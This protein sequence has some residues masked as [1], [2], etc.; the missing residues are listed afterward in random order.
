[1]QYSTTT[2]SLTEHC[3][4]PDHNH[5]QDQLRRAY[6]CPPPQQRC[7]DIDHAAFGSTV[8]ERDLGGRDTAILVSLLM[9]AS[10]LN[11]TR[12][13][14]A[15]RVLFS[16]ALHEEGAEEGKGV[17][18]TSAEPCSA[19]VWQCTCTVYDPPSSGSPRS[20][21]PAM[22]N[23][24]CAPQ[25]LRTHIRSYCAATLSMYSNAASPA[26]PCRMDMNGTWL[27]WMGLR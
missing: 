4:T 10:P 12:S 6:H 7:S 23:S 27:G 5:D 3:T 18:G 24:T 25:H 20:L 11:R 1:M 22:E 16:L 14:E 13:K 15:Q 17:H 21:P 9:N 8:A 2:Y 26:T 19:R